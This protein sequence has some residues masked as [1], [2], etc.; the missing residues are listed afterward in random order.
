MKVFVTA[1]DSGSLKE[2]TFAAGTNTS[3]PDAPQPQIETFASAGR[4]AYVQ[5]MILVTLEDGKECVCI[6][7]KGGVIQLYD[8]HAPHELLVE[9]TDKTHA[10]DDAFVG[11]EHVDGRLSSCTTTGRLVMRDLTALGGDENK[12]TT[13]LGEPVNA[14]RVH[15]RQPNV[16]AV[17]GK[18]RELE[19]LSIGRM[20][21]AAA[22]AGSAAAGAG[23]TAAEPT[24]TKF[25]YPSKLWK[26]K[27]VS[28]DELNLRVPVWI[29]DIRFLDVGRDSK[30][31]WRVAVTTRF[32]HVRLY[33][34][35]RSQRPILNVEVGDHPL[36]CLA[37]TGVDTDVVY[38][39]TH[40]T[41]ARF[42]LTRGSKLGH[43]KGAVGST[44]SLNVHLPAAG[45]DSAPLLATGGLDRYLRVYNLETREQVA[46][47]FV[48]TK[49]SAVQIA[50]AS[51]ALP[52]IKQEDEAAVALEE[53]E[54]EAE[55]SAKRKPG[56]GAGPEAEADELWGALDI[57]AASDSEKIEDE[58]GT[59]SATRPAAAP[60]AERKPKA[61]ARRKRP[62]V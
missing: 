20:H 19:L 22:W 7:R 24:L 23:A 5:R 10:A 46:K 15:P 45:D 41:T 9:W 52:A 12:Q 47:V 42:S 31:G 34:T 6:A 14:F 25:L 1:E 51:P 54:A 37:P 33:E 28:N 60:A 62:R 38:S 39:D 57:E 59:S 18:E 27:N 8:V 61:K 40:S 35:K 3:I 16:I 55:R 36:V 4:A 58:A 21:E 48:G 2:V 43:Y 11:L 53:T 49:I 29:S 50:D 13:V 56:D 17:G 30:D 32:G 44:T 26:A